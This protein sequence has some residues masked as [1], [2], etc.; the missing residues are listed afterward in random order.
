[1]KVHFRFRFMILM[2]YV[3]IQPMFANAQEQPNV[4]FFLE[5]DLG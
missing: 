5:D 3:L 2:Q 4:V 1:M